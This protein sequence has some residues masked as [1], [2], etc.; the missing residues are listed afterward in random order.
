MEK[1]NKVLV[2]VNLINN[3]GLDKPILFAG[4]WCLKKDKSQIIKNRSH[5]F[6]PSIFDKK[7][8][9]LF[10]EEIVRL[11]KLIQPKII[12]NLN[13]IHNV[14]YDLNFWNLILDPWLGDYLEYNFTRWLTIEEV[15]DNNQ[16]TSFDFFSYKFD[17][18]QFV[19]FD[20][21]SSFVTP[22]LSSD[23]YNQYFYQEIINFFKN[24]KNINFIDTGETL[25]YQSKKREKSNIFHFNAK[26]FSSYLKKLFI[27]KNRIYINA[28]DISRIE[29]LKINLAIGQ[30]PFNPGFLFSEKN[31][32]NILSEDI[33][34]YDVNLRNK[35]TFNFQKKINF[36]SYIMNRIKFDLPN[37]TLENFKKI[38]SF[39]ESL[40]LHQKYIISGGDHF[41]NVLFKFWMAFNKNNKNKILTLDHGIHNGVERGHVFYQEEIGDINLNFYKKMKPKEVQLPSLRLSKYINIR[42]RNR[43]AD[44]LLYVS[45]DNMIYPNNILISPICSKSKYVIEYFQKL[46]QYLREDINKDVLIRPT[47]K[48]H[49]PVPWVKDEL[50]EKFSKNYKIVEKNYIN[51]YRE[52][53]IVVCTYPQTSFAEAL[54]SGP[55]ILLTKL[56]F[57]P[58]FNKFEELKNDM[59]ASKIIF[60]DPI[61]AAKHI[62]NVWDNPS[63]WWNSK[64]VKIVRQKF[65]NETAL[66]SN[67]ALNLFINYL[68]EIKK[69]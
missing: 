39:I 46:T 67:K 13:K 56:D 44:K 60:Q 64:N 10:K 34:K 17:K 47:F 29:L 42:E 30:F 65:I 31:Y 40:N 68:N 1:A 35:I 28:W 20:V 41:Y 23:I 55:A 59:I 7:K 16:N 9:L 3:I 69:K 66:A 52:S 2:A 12:E 63:D 26:K 53:K 24:E 4:D 15:I 18:S 38:Y 32:M 54:I 43:L 45:Y 6:F 48:K 14:N 11:R 58:Y 36:E 62:N 27:G 50:I 51:F 33:L 21:Q 19:C 22:N 37:Y 5:V 49:F 8:L 25:T 57:W 61:E